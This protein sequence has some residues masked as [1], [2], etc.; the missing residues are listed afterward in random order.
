M[1][2]YFENILLVETMMIIQDK[3]GQFFFVV[4]SLEPIL[5]SFFYTRTSCFLSILLVSRRMHS[6][7]IKYC[8][9]QRKRQ[10]RAISNLSIHRLKQ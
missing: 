4:L 7:Y 1:G 2:L 3:L 8:L 5:L 9:L 6:S 10:N